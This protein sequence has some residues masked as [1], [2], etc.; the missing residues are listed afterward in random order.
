MDCSGSDT[1][2]HSQLALALSTL[3]PAVAQ[4]LDTAGANYTVFVPDDTS[5]A[6]ITKL[7]ANK[8][9]TGEEL[10]K[11]RGARV[12]VGRWPK[13]AALCAARC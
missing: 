1:C 12:E 11:V 5:A 4:T 3:F 2:D 10:I 6:A 7:Y 13:E 9:L 8:E